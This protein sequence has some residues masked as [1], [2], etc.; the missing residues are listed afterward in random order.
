VTGNTQIVNSNLDMN[1][2][3]KIINVASPTDNGDA[4]N[5]EFLDTNFFNKTTATAQIVNSNLDMNT[6]RIY[7]LSNPATQTMP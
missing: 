1:T 6:K 3:N 4:V 5:K 2:T 7:N